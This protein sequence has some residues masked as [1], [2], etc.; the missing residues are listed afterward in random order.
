MM[1]DLPDTEDHDAASERYWPEGYKDIIREKIGPCLVRQVLEAGAF[2]SAYE[3]I[4]AEKFDTYEEFVTR[5][6]EMVSIGAEKGADEM[7]EDIYASFR[8]D[9]PLP[10]RR[11][12]ACYL[13]PEP[14]DQESK[15]EVYQKL[16]EE[17]SAHHAYEHIHEDH[18]K[19]V[20]DFETFITQVADLV[21][22]GAI[23]GADNA[24]EAL[25]KAFLTASPLPPARRKPRRIQ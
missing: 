5:L 24:L 8:R 22:I 17:Y 12:R 16:F 9:V 21:L 19:D 20:M 11:A 2:K 3:N 10:E 13:W 1:H 18:Y 14:F 23:N 7:F 25:Y 4:Y 6:G 15:D